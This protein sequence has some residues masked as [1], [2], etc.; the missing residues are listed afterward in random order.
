MGHAMGHSRNP[1]KTQYVEMESGKQTKKSSM[2]KW[3][4]AGK[5]E[6]LA[7]WDDSG[8]IIQKDQALR[9]G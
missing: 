6:S 7:S 9:D 4:I 3:A 1:S 5:L 8:N 2:L